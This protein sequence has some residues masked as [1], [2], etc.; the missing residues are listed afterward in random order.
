MKTYF[1]SRL[2][3]EIIKIRPNVYIQCYSLLVLVR[4][5]I[6]QERTQIEKVL[7]CN[8]DGNTAT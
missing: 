6:F 4:N 5:V 7:N 8:A 2:I 1:S 3:L